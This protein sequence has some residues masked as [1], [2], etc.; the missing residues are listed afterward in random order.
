MER[1]GGRRLEWEC[2]MRE[3]EIWNLQHA[4]QGRHVGKTETE[5]MSGNSMS[6]PRNRYWYI[7]KKNKN[8]NRS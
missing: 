1:G 4:R 5:L 7:S 3:R 8:L 6:F 2:G